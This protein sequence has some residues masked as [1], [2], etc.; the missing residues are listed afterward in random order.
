[1]KNVTLAIVLF[2]TV[3]VT[4]L[5]L[6]VY[7]VLWFP[8]FIHIN[9]NGN[10]TESA[11]IYEISIQTIPSIVNGLTTV[12]G[13][14]VGFSATVLGIVVRDILKDSDK[15]QKIRNYLVSVI[16]FT[17]PLVLIMD[18]GAYTSLLVGGGFE[19]RL[20]LDLVLNGFLTAL[21]D[22]IGIFIIIWLIVEERKAKKIPLSQPIVQPTSS[23]T[24]PEPTKAEEKTS[25]D[26]NKTVNITINME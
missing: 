2:S 26:G 9:T 17:F 16:L 22:L 18:Y 14:L 12:T 25:N 23:P 13:I 4:F 7:N 21:L 6:G 11:R 19:F 8:T 5:V 20:S 1:V 15:D 10:A 3:A 24:T